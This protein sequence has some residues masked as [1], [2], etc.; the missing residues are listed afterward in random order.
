MLQENMVTRR[1]SNQLRESRF[2]NRPDME[3]EQIAFP[4]TT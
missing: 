3:R 2:R 4:D 1:R